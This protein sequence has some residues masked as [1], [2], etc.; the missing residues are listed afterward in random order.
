MSERETRPLPGVLPGRAS[1]RLTESAADSPPPHRLDWWQHVEPRLR[2]WKV[3]AGL[4]RYI[5]TPAVA[6]RRPFAWPD[7]RSAQTIS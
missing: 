4:L 2:M 5:V 6:K 3:L 7:A 1:A